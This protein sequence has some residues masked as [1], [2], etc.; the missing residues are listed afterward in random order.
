MRKRLLLWA[1]VW[2]DDHKVLIYGAQRPVV[3]F[4]RA[5]AKRWILN[6]NAV[7]VCIARYRAEARKGKAE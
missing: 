1:V 3:F 7:A 4:T 6:S 2:K 5:E